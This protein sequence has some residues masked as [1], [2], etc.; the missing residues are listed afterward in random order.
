[1]TTTPIPRFYQLVDAGDVAGLVAM[2][3]PDATYHRPGYPPLHGRPGIEHFYTHERVI[4]EGRH[5]LDSVVVTGHEVAVRG[6][7]SGRLRD[8]SPAAHRFAEFFT[9]D[10]DHRIE[11]RETFFSAPLV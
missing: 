7:F 6:S 4:S 2:F 3:A 9:L 1:M 5:A 11:H 10:A 8:G